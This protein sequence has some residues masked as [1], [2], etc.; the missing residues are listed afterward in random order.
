ML[1]GSR[2]LYWP[3]VVLLLGI[4]TVVRVADPF[5]VYGLRLLAFDCT[6]RKRRFESSKSMRHRWQSL[7]TTSTV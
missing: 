2:H 6:T 3:F 1:V 7:G 4:A 5:F